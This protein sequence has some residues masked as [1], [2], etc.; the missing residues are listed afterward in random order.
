MAAV[1]TLTGLR[2]LVEQRFTTAW[3]AATPI[4][5]ENVPFLEPGA[6]AG[7][8]PQSAA[9]S[10]VR[11]TVREGDEE[12]VT[13]GNIAKVRVVGMV[14]IDVFSPM[15][16]GTATPRGYA[17]TAAQIFRRVFV[18]GVQF[19]APMVV[20]LGDRGEGWWQIQVQVPF[21]WDRIHTP[22]S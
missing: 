15:G 19:R 3:A 20:A 14:F 9:S 5:Y 1:T 10:W 17:E 21:W 18:D 22:A 12:T 2:A 6:D 8:D 4:A 16:I 13:V 11:I 7:T